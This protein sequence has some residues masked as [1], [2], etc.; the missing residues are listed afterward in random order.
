METQNKKCKCECHNS[1]WE[2]CTMCAT[3]HQPAEKECR[4]IWAGD[5]IFGG[6]SECELCG[7]IKPE[8]SKTS[9]KC[10][11]L[12]ERNTCTECGK[13]LCCCEFRNG[14]S[15]TETPEQFWQ[16]VKDDYDS[17]NEPSK[18]NKDFYSDLP[19]MVCIE[20]DDKYIPKFS[21]E[22]W[23]EKAWE[24]YRQH[25]KTSSMEDMKMP[26][27]IFNKYIK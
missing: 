20:L 27:F 8:L 11:D 17:S 7:K 18:L 3:H 5:A 21:K 14:S 24:E 26:G 13:Q 22:K 4:H 10:T 1:G 15:K 16:K 23:F 25:I 19:A 2:N 6:K 12:G 9:E